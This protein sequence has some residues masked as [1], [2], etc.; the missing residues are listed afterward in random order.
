MPIIV[1]LIAVLTIHVT[2]IGATGASRSNENSGKCNHGNM[3]N[4]D[5]GCVARCFCW[6]WNKYRRGDHISNCHYCSQYIII[7]QTKVCC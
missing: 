3:N 5:N 2:C 1:I 7:L 4:I 6:N